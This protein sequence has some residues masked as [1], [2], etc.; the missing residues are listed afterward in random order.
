[1]SARPHRTDPDGHRGRPHA[2]ALGRLVGVELRKMLDTRAGFWMQVATVVLTVWSPS[3]A[4]RRRR[5]GPH[6]HLRPRRR[7]LP[8]GGPSAGRRHPARHLRV[9]PA[10][11][12]DHLRAGA[13]AISGPR[14]QAP[15]E[16]DPRRRDARHR[17][18]GRRRGGVRRVAG[19][20]RRLDR[21]PAA[22]AESAVYLTAGMSRASRSA[23]SCSP[24]LPPSSRSSRCR[25][26]GRPSPPCRCS[27]TPR[28][29]STP[30]CASARSPRRSS[31]RPSGRARPRRSRLDAAAA[32]IGT[33]RITRREVA[34]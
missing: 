29:G 24:P 3:S 19:R 7:T 23:W 11:R 30:A 4:P 14:R 13:R 25:S 26:R 9:V 33:W 10:D 28:R 8:R 21:R 31:A 16:P 18:R 27:P 12:D 2:P 5:G 20:R 32:A 6:V 34:P 17:R 22:I 15:R 1:M